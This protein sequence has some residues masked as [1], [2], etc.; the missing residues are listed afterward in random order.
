MIYYGQLMDFLLSPGL[1]LN[2]IL[3]SATAELLII[4]STM[5]YILKQ[6]FSRQNTVIIRYFLAL[7]AM[8]SINDRPVTLISYFHHQASPLHC[9]NIAKLQVTDS[10]PFFIRKKMR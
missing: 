2:R 8:T 7:N 1:F 4:A 9:Y 3:Q 5:N 6:F 10:T